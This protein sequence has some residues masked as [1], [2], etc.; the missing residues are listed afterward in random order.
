MVI[1][2]ICKM[3]AKKMVL[4]YSG[5]NILQPGKTKVV[6]RVSQKEEP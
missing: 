6:N 1:F 3:Q 5:L 2:T 4:Q